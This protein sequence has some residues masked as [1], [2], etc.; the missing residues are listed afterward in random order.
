MD[1]SGSTYRRRQ[2]RVLGT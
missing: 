2:S 1:N